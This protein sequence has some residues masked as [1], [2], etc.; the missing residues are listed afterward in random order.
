M[1]EPKRKLSPLDLLRIEPDVANQS[2]WL[3]LPGGADI[4]VTDLFLADKSMTVEQYLEQALVN[5]GFL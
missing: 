5:R 4:Y 1:A 2:Y 3:R